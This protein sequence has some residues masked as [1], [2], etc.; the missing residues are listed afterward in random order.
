MEEPVLDRDEMADEDSSA[1]ELPVGLAAGDGGLARL[2]RGT[3][4]GAA[5]AV[6]PGAVGSMGAAGDLRR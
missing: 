2:V 6:D 4:G 5:T 3:S 1:H